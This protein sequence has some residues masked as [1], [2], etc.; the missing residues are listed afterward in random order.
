MVLFLV[1]ALVILVTMVVAQVR[2]LGESLP[3]YRD[4]LLQ[5]AMTWLE[6]LTG[7]DIYAWRD[8]SRM[9]ELVREH[10]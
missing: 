2:T 6:S 10:S 9:L 4:W 3:G 7:I 5:T 8:P 1:L